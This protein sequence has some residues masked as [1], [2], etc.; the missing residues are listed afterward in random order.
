MGSHAATGDQTI[1]GLWLVGSEEVEN[2]SQF[3]PTFGIGLKPDFS[4]LGKWLTELSTFPPWKDDV[5]I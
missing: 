1:C 2:V 5:G 3:S 4:K